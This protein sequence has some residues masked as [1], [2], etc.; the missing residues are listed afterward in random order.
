MLSAI[1]YAGIFQGT[2]IGDGH[3]E[4]ALC[5][6]QP[7]A[8]LLHE[9]LHTWKAAHINSPIPRAADAR[10]NLWHS[11]PLAACKRLQH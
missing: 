2:H 10:V 11:R 7:R 5:I 9:Q 4:W 6:T 3:A 1:S 8:N